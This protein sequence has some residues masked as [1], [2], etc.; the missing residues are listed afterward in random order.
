MN[1]REYCNKKE[2]SYE[3]NDKF[4]AELQNYDEQEATKKF[5]RLNDEYKNMSN[6]ELK[7]A[8]FDFVREYKAGGKDVKGELDYIYNTLKA[9][10]PN[11]Q[12]ENIENLIEE[13]KNDNNQT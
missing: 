8:L 9:F 4:N 3:N 12:L 7:G 10:L 1:F 5:D 6:T 2:C 11:E 13:L